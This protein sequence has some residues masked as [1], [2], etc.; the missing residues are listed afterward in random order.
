MFYRQKLSKA[1]SIIDD[2]EWDEL[3]GTNNPVE[4]INRQSTPDNVK[5]VS[6][7][8][9]VEHFCLEDRRQA[10]LQTASEAEVTIS[11][12]TKK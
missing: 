10:V 3:P 5:S 4:S 1:F 6:L 2:D 11:Y 9:L 8:P 7:R 12:K